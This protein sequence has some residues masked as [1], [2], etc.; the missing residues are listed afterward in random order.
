MNYV[1]ATLTQF[2]ST[3]M[4]SSFNYETLLFRFMF[5]I[6]MLKEKC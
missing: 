2:S 6:F 3:H 5:D 4:G 1:Q